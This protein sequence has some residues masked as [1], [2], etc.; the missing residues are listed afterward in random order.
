M[1]KNDLKLI[2]KVRKMRKKIKT[3]K[4]VAIA[5]RRDVDKISTKTKE[6]QSMKTRLNNCIITSYKESA[7][8]FEIYK[9]VGA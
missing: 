7:K 1:T 8:L 9:R 4:F 2:N 6:Y 3:L 5:I